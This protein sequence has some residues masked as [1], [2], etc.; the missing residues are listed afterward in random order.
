[1]PAIRDQADYWHVQGLLNAGR[2]GEAARFVTSE[3]ANFTASASPGKSSLCLAA[4][5][6][7]AAAS[8]SGADD[9]RQL[10]EQGIRGLARMRQFETLDQTIEKYKLDDGTDRGRFSRAF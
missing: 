1:P 2:V 6:A 3:V 7:G 10:V 9:R 8:T 4:I 5:R